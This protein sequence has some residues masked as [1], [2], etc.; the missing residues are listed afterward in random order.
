VPDIPV[1]GATMIIACFFKRLPETNI[2][3]GSLARCRGRQRRI[4]L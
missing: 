2:R 4:W 1:H 3:T